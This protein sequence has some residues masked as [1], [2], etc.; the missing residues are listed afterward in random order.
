MKDR[1]IISGWL[2]RLSCELWKIETYLHEKDQKV[3]WDNTIKKYR[4]KY[5]PGKSIKAIEK[6][7]IANLEFWEN[8]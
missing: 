4:D 6:L 7:A 3:N 2:Y 5:A 1:K 8:Q